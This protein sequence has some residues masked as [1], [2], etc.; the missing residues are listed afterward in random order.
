MVTP[1]PT[2]I[3]KVILQVA[4]AL[5]L[6]VSTT[7]CSLL[8]D[9]STPQQ[10]TLEMED[11]FRNDWQTFKESAVD[12]NGSP[13]QLTLL[14][15]GGNADAE[16]GIWLFIDGIMQPYKVETDGEEQLMHVF[17]L[18]ANT[19]IEVVVTVDPTVGQ[20]G[21]TLYLS[22]VFI[23]NPYSEPS[24]D[25]NSANE[26]MVLSSAFSVAVIY[27]V[28]CTNPDSR[29]PDTNRMEGPYR[30]GALNSISF[31]INYGMDQFEV[32]PVSDCLPVKVQ[33][34]SSIKTNYRIYVFVNLKPQCFA[35][36]ET[37]M[38]VSTQTNTTTF[39]DLD[40]DFS[41]YQSGEVISVFA[42]VI[43]LV[44]YNMPNGTS[45]LADRTMVYLFIKQ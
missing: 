19:D 9:S 44:D 38:F 35:N 23:V 33:F 27:N 6:L 5:C 28:D 39:I 11:R 45:N 29:L 41:S 2:T 18:P 40:L 42:L 13:I 12:Y 3:I 32:H 14:L 21:E 31:L 20:A 26:Q 4:L 7:G 17:A 37:S 1:K 34:S 15:S 30:W 22:S 16:I 24:S 25:H 43:P 10:N 8:V 36:G